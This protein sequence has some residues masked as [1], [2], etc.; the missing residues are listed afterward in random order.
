[1]AISSL[2][3]SGIKSV[4]QTFS[5]RSWGVGPSVFSASLTFFGYKIEF[6]NQYCLWCL[7]VQCSGCWGDFLQ[8]AGS[9]PACRTIRNSEQG[10]TCC[11]TLLITILGSMIFDSFG[12]KPLISI[13]YL[14]YSYSL[15]LANTYVLTC[16][17]VGVG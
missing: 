11:Y 16:F 7:A 9:K 8:V 14:L 3:L 10:Q 1:M 5:S 6:I 4:L 13:G 2:R 17:S 12:K 15:V